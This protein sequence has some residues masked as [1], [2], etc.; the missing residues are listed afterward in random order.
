MR[1]IDVIYRVNSIKRRTAPGDDFFVTVWSTL[2]D[3]E[4]KGKEKANRRESSAHLL[5]FLSELKIDI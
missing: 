4:R 2:R 1:T 5:E 3:W